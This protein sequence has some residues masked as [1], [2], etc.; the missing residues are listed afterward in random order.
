[1]FSPIRCDSLTQVFPRFAPVTRICDAF[2]L[3]QWFVCVWSVITL[4]LVYDTLSLK[5]VSGRMV[6]LINYRALKGP[7]YGL[8]NRQNYI[9]VLGKLRLLILEHWNCWQASLIAD[10]RGNRL[11]LQNLRLK[12]SS[13]FC[14]SWKTVVWFLYANQGNSFLWMSF[15]YRLICLLLV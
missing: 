7:C 4:G 3:V 15:F 2:W 1:M 5:S 8:F 10:G 6:H 13:C 14:A 11:Q 9:C 12:F